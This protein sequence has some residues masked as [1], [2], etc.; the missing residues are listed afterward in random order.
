MPRI[1]H[2]LAACLAAAALPT[3]AIELTDVWYHPG[4]PG[5]SVNIVHHDDLAWVAL[6]IYGPAGEAQWYSTAARTT[7]LGPGGM[8]QMTGT[9]YR[10]RG[11]VLGQPFDPGK[12]EV[13][14]V[15]VLHLSTRDL[16]AIDLEYTIDGLQ[17]DKTLQR[18]TWR[19]EVHGE[20][21]LASFAGHRTDSA[22]RVT[23]AFS[24]A[25]PAFLE[26]ESGLARLRMSQS[27]AA[28]DYLGGHRPM[29][30]IAEVTGDFQC[31]DGRAGRF[32]LT[33]LTI[34]DHGFSGRLKTVS[35][36]VTEVGALG[37]GKNPAYR[38]ATSGGKG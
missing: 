38:M 1:T 26:I 17:I 15:G 19:Q 33:D 28:C 23:T 36:S 24:H 9:L 27:G 8:P 29:G 13:M 11:P 34:T 32:E 18:F 22:T 20:G 14:P 31:D 35:G 4:E 21:Y 25:G 30:R 37:G 12:V 5:W 6:Y 3:H 16:D 2:L 7:A 10:T